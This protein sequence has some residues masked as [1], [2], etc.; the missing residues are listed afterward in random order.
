MQVSNK[1]GTVTKATA[2][3]Q[4]KIEDR[5]L[6][7]NT[8]TS[9]KQN[10]VTK[11][12]KEAM[13]EFHKL[14]VTASKD[15]SNPHFSSSYAT[16]ESVIEAVNQGNKFGLFF[17]QEIK[18]IDMYEGSTETT[19]TM[20]TPLVRTTVHHISDDNT[21]VSE[22]PI[23]LQPASLQNPQKLGAAITYLKRYTLQSVY[24]LPSEDDDGNQASSETK[25][26]N[27]SWR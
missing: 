24:G 11:N 22:C 19:Q 21:Y 27:N 7:G 5:S 20:V 13:L 18:Y 9:S 26:S 3:A 6:Q 17:T 16:L 4:Q 14:S 25:T 2:P 12:L 10:K 23:L 15:G 8:N 1:N